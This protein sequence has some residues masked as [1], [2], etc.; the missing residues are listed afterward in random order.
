MKLQAIYYDL[1]VYGSIKYAGEAQPF[2]ALSTLKYKRDTAQTPYEPVITL[3]PDSWSLDGSRVSLKD[4]APPP[5]WGRELSDGA[6]ELSHPAT[7]EVTLDRLCSAG[8][9]TLTF[10]E[11][12]NQWCSRIT[13]SWYRGETLLT[14]ETVYPASPRLVVQKRVED[15]DRLVL[16][17]EQTSQP[18]RFPR[19][20]YLQLGREMVF[21][22]NSLVSVKMLTEYDPTGCTLSADTMTLE[23]C[24]DLDIRSQENQKLELYRDGTLAAAFYVTGS[25]RTGQTGYTISAQSVIGVLEEQVRLPMFEDITAYDAMDA[26]MDDV[27]WELDS[28]FLAQIVSGYL[29]VCSR[30]E[31]LQQ[32]AFALGARVTA[33]DGTVRLL[34]AEE[35]VTHS[36]PAEQTF[37]GGRVENRSALTRLEVTAHSY[38]PGSEE[39]LLLDDRYVDGEEVLFVMDSPCG[40]YRVEGGEFV[41]GGP[42]YVSITA[43]G[44]IRLYGKPYIHTGEIHSRQRSGSGSVLTVDQA[45]LVNAGNVSAV[46]DRLMTAGKALQQLQQ[47]VVPQD[48]FAGQRVTATTPWGSTLTGVIT[49]LETRMTPAGQTATV[50]I[51]GNEVN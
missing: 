37:S 21:D 38:T 22:H 50:T 14:G 25:R 9:V 35:E 18:Y 28:S 32:L 31:A 46:M 2:C 13:L 1:P 27:P 47:D 45:T 42:G 24:S 7:V 16:S 11:E 3:E 5:F 33:A 17:M 43:H 39:R 48:A 34:R 36:F 10:W 49:S 6:G 19:L 44:V 40:E 20:T 26:I 15:F 29:P 4:Y 23:V 51:Q 12:T 41:G 30:R 8:G